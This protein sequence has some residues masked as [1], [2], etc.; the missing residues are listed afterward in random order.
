MEN[1]KFN[2][3]K[4]I[5][6]I[7]VT[8]PENIRWISGFKGSFG[9]VLLK[10]NGEKILISDG[11]Y[12]ENAKRTLK[13]N[14]EARENALGQTKEWKFQIFDKDFKKNFGEKVSG[15]FW[16][17]DL[18]SLADLKK[19]KKFFPN[20][21][22]FPKTNF[23]EEKR[24]IKTEIEIDKVRIAQNHVDDLLIPFL[25]TKLRENV[26]EKLLA[27]ELE[28]A[29][30][31]NGKFDISFDAI[32]AFGENSSLPHHHPSEKKLKKGDNILIDCGAKFEGYHSDMTRNFVF[33]TAKADY[34]NKFN[35]CLN[36][37]KK[38]LAQYKVGKK[39]KDLENFCR[40]SLGEEE[41]YFTHSLGH[42]VGLQIHEIPSISIKSK[43]KLIENQIV[44]CEPGLYYPDNFGIRIEDLLVIRKNGPEILSQTKKELILF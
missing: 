23:L 17:E 12:A 35:I 1:I 16:I 25:K 38:V 15:S 44:T 11:R 21:K 41:K 36:A 3:T 2:F 8:T 18:A 20:I 33:G 40:K 32:V 31:D 14:C 28:H 6:G 10:K 4:N 7:L 29:I 22:F 34:I 5:D 42:G 26:T 19:Y 24:S 39:I 9:L 43:D 27:F 30:R 37:Q 13:V